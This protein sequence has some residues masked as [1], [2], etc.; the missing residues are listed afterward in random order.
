[1]ESQQETATATA[2]EP[3]DEQLREKLVQARE[4]L[5]LQ[6]TSAL[7]VGEMFSLS[8]TGLCLRCQTKLPEDR[9][10]ICESC[11]VK[12]DVALEVRK[13]RDREEATESRF[14]RSGLPKA[15]L[16][17]TITWADVSRK[18]GDLAACADV[19][20]AGKGLFLYG[21]AGTFKTS[22]A[23]SYLAEMIRTGSR[24]QY[25]YVPDLFTE[26]AAI[27]SADDARSRADVID[28]YA[29][30]P[31]LVMD[32][33]DKAKPSR[34]A[35]EV[36]LA[37]LDSRYREGERCLFVTANVSIDDLAVPFAEAVGENF[38]EPLV[39]RLSE[40]CASVPMGAV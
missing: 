18:L 13:A 2:P 38:S 39:R 12:V 30:A 32:D 20:R 10:A 5:G 35:A 33:L 24:G 40:L 14:R 11:D 7:E 23:A 3:T 37:I 19:M 17:G 15:F 8:R 4:L 26:L 1:M 6:K 31:W 36:L 9:I 21:P 34:H 16:D 25:V 29:L 27:Y 28:R 22:F